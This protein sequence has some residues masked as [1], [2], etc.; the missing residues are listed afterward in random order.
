M[1]SNNERQETGSKQ[2]KEL[3][4]KIAETELNSSKIVEKNDLFE[5]FEEDIKQTIGE[6]ELEKELNS[7]YVQ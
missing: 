7:F 1:N 2:V 6:C 5:V 3:V 4:D